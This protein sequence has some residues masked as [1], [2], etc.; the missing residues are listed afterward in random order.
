MDS[1]KFEDRYKAYEQ[2]QRI[3]YEDA[4]MI[5]LFDLGVWEGWQNYVKGYEPWYMIQ[6]LNTW[7][8]K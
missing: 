1:V 8:D 4:V 7:V 6:F 5:K 3:F 2:T